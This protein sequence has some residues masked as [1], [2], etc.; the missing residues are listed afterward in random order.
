MRQEPLSVELGELHALDPRNFPKA[1]DFIVDLRVA[2]SETSLRYLAPSLGIVIT[3][4][5]WNR[6]VGE[7][8]NW[9]SSEIPCGSINSPYWD[10]DQGWAL[11]IWRSHDQIHIAEGDRQ[12]EGD[13]EGEI[14]ERW[15]AVSED[16]YWSEWEKAIKGISPH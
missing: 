11:L 15:F 10:R 3:F 8:R 2:G 9:T 12:A 4:P 5:W 14:Y 7:I 6:T 13:D 1:E 16:I